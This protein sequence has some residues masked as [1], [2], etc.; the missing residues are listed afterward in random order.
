MQ[1]EHDHNHCH[2]R[3]VCVLD[4]IE[5]VHSSIK[6]LE[7]SKVRVFFSLK[8][9]FHYHRFPYPP[10]SPNMGTSIIFLFLLIIEIPVA[11]SASVSLS[12]REPLDQVDISVTYSWPTSK[13]N[14]DTS[15]Q[16]LSDNGGNECTNNREYVEWAGDND[17]TGGS[18]SALVLLA[19]ARR[20]NAISSFAVLLSCDSRF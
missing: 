9:S 16:F 17:S 5:Q 15:T 4:R 11:F 2:V 7:R 6:G 13:T 20:L 10:I 12:A 8:S 19:K 3:Q 14:L 1:N 18:E